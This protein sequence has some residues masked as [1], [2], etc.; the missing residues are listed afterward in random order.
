MQKDKSTK[1][2]GRRRRKAKSSRWRARNGCISA[3][4]AAR[5]DLEKAKTSPG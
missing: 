5:I 2:R 4:S 3:N 1:N